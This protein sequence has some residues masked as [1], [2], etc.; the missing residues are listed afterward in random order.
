MSDIK[1]FDLL[2]EREMPPSQMLNSSD[3]RLCDTPMD[4]RLAISAT[5]MSRH[6]L[7]L[8]VNFTRM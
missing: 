1:P 7:F 2:G 3:V 8:R 4:S 5:V 6:I